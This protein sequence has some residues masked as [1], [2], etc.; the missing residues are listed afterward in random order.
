MNKQL[1]EMSLSFYQV[2][3]HHLGRSSS[4]THFSF[5]QVYPNP[6]AKEICNLYD[7]D[8]YSDHADTMCNLPLILPENNKDDYEYQKMKK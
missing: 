5:T 4:V 2:Q 7:P 1:A 3:I 8:T 6:T